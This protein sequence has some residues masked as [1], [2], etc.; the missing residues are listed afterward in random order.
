MLFLFN[1]Y[2]VNHKF[3][4]CHKVCVCI[5][6]YIQPPSRTK[7][8]VQTHRSPGT[9]ASFLSLWQYLLEALLSSFLVCLTQ[10]APQYI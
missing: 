6:I 5:C 7:E 10:P 9:T 8:P 3:G 1:R 4:L 2:Q